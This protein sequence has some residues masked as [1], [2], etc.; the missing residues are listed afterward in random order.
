MTKV[1]KATVVQSTRGEGHTLRQFDKNKGRL[2]ATPVKKGLEMFA[3]GTEVVIIEA[4]EYERLVK[5]DPFA[6]YT[7]NVGE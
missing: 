4:S 5:V 6:R 2:A 3:D 1:M 7:T